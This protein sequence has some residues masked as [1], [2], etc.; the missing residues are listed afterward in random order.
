MSNISWLSVEREILLL[1]VL[2]FGLCTAS[3]ILTKRL[4]AIVRY[5]K[6][7]NVKIVLYLDDGLAMAESFEECRSISNFIKSSLEDAGL[8]IN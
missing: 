7:N 8:L 5:L 2:P 4:R 3:H 1:K 6:S